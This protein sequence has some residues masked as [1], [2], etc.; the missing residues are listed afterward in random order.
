MTIDPMPGW[1]PVNNPQARL[2]TA[3]GRALYGFPPSIDP[4]GGCG[5]CRNMYKMGFPG[6][7]FR[8]NVI[9]YGAGRIERDYPV[10]E[11]LGGHDITESMVIPPMWVGVKHALVFATASA[12]IPG[13]AGL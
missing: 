11:R 13:V 1:D 4:D 7:S 10:Q 5:D 6:M 9:D 3:A 12:G 8:G 2:V